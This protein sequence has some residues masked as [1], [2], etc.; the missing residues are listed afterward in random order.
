MA[1]K[2]NYHWSVEE[3][4]TITFRGNEAY[5]VVAFTAAQIPDIDGRKYPKRIGRRPLPGRNSDFVEDDLE[6]LI[7]EHNAEDCVF[8]L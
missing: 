5:N 1:K 7:K 8:V 6:K 2:C 3:I 4:S